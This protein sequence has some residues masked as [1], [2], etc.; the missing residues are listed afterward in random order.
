MIQIR[1]ARPFANRTALIACV[2]LLLQ[3]CGGGGG[4]NSGGATLPAPPPRPPLPPPPSQPSNPQRIAAATT[5][6]QGDTNACASIR[7][8]YWE[9]GDK[10]SGLASG[11]VDSATDPTVYK[12][13]T[14]MAI[15]SASKWVYAA[16]VAQMRPGPLTTEDIKFLT[17]RSGYTSFNGCL[18]GQSVD[19]CVA[20]ADNGLYHPANDGMFSYGG[21]HMQKHASLI[22]LGPLRNDGLAAEVRAKIGNDIALLYTQPQLAGGLFT[23]ASDYALFLRRLLGNQLR[24]GAMLGANAVCTNP[25]TCAQARNTPVP[26]TE[27][28]NYSLGHWVEVDPLV[29]DGAFSSAGAFGFYPWIDASKTWYGIVAR[30]QATA[31]QDTDQNLGEGYRSTQC[32]RLIRKAWVTATVQ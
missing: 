11:S 18:Q 7:P 5:T 20:F 22:G 27:S 2:L 13:D 9:V 14:P 28:W 21:G 29:G 6:A 15:A 4:G 26:A 10:S 25:G 16:Y 3:G 19:E 17:F 31:G 8:F 30:K 23:T 12:A 1:Q 32:G 24:L